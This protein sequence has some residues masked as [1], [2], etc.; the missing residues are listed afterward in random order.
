MNFYFIDC[1]YF[2]KKS[3]EIGKTPAVIV[4][5]PFYV[6][7]VKS[8]QRVSV[9]TEDKLYRISKYEK[10]QFQKYGYSLFANLNDLDKDHELPLLQVKEY[11]LNYSDFEISNITSQMDENLKNKYKAE[12]KKMDEESEKRLAK[13]RRT[14]IKPV[15]K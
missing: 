10:E 3:G 6:F 15:R 14:A 8:L 9:K 13:L 4:K 2:N 1:N 12:L 11:M 5:T 7:E